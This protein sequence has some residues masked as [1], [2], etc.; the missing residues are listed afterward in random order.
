VIEASEV[1]PLFVEAGVAFLGFGALVSLFGKSAVSTEAALA[2]A[3]LR[4]MLELNL[5]LLVC[6]VVPFI[7]EPWMGSEVILWRT[8]CVGPLALSIW[9]SIVFSARTRPYRSATPIW[10]RRSLQSFGLLTFAFSLLGVLSESGSRAMACFVA[11]LFMSLMV[12]GGFFALV[13]SVAFKLA[14][15]RQPSK[16]T[17]P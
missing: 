11:A 13:T 4:C 14:T 1:L 5:A 12:S 16:V 17:G 8:L 3:R 7:L 9:A 15:E 2:S 10:V 6:A